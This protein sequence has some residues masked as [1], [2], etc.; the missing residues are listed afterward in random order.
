MRRGT[1]PGDVARA[2]GY[3]TAYL[4]RLFRQVHGVTLG[5]FIQRVQVAQARTLLQ[6][7]ASPLKQ[8]ASQCGFRDVGYFRRL[9]RRELGLSPRE[10]R[11]RFGQ[12][13]I[14]RD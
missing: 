9:F 1:S 8:I 2:V 14:N 11:N 4:S 13:R 7:S 10:Y 5:R 12:V 6:D 3:N